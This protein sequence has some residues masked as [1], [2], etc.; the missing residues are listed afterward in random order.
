MI[1][2]ETVYIRYLFGQRILSRWGPDNHVLHGEAL[3]G[4][5]YRHGPDDWS[6][7]PNH[8]DCWQSRH[9]CYAP[10]W[11]GLWLRHYYGNFASLRKKKLS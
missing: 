10:H 3:Y 2:N 11:L 6:A 9:V 4:Q 5:P 1:K 8:E 7:K